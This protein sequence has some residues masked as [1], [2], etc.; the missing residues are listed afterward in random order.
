MNTINLFPTS[1]FLLVPVVAEI[2]G[3]ENRDVLFFFP[4]KSALTLAARETY[5]SS[6]YK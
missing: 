3:R 5:E 1:S 2:A 6:E 4:S